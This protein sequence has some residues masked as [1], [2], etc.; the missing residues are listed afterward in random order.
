MSAY[1]GLREERQWVAQ[2]VRQIDRM[3][4]VD[5]QGGGER[6]R[7]SDRYDDTVRRQRRTLTRPH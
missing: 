5:I 3:V 4:S 6:T 7:L 2:L 1:R